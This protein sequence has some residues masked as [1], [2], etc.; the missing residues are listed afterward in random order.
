MKKVWFLFALVFLV[1]ATTGSGGALQNKPDWEDPSVIGINK[2]DPHASFVPYSDDRS[3]LEGKDP[4]Q[5]MSLN[6][7]WKFNYSKDPWHRPEGFYKPGFDA[8][9]WDTIPVPSNWEMLGYGT[10]IYTNYTYPFKKNAPKVTSRPRKSWTAYDARNPVGSYLKTFTVPDT[11]QGKEIYMVFHGVDSAFYLWINGEKVGYSQGSRLPAEFNVTDFLKPGGNRLAALV[12]RWCD[13]S[14]LEDQDFWRLSGIYRNVELVARPPLHVRDFYVRTDFDENYRDADF[15]LKIE[16]RNLENSGK[17]ASITAALFDDSGGKVFADL[18]K[19][20]TVDSKGR[21]TVT[22]TKHV[23]SPRKWSAEMPYLYQLL[24]TLKDNN[25]ETLESIPFRVGFRETEIKDSQILINGRPIYLKGA[26]RHEHD[27]DTG[28][29]VS[30]ESMI[31]DIKIMK[32]NNL[33]AVRTSHYPCTPEW[34]SLC[35]EYGLY[36]LDE[37]NIESHG[38]GVHMLQRTSMGPDYKEQHVDRIRRMVER[39]KNHPS[40]FA[41]SLGNEAGVGLNLSAERKWVNKHYPEFPVFYEQGFGVHSDALCPMYTPPDNLVRNW[42]LYGFGKPMFLVEYAHSMGN[43]VGDFKGYWEVMESHDF[44]QGGF[45]WDWVDQGLRK[46]T[47]DGEE[48]WAYGGDYGDEPNDGNFCLNGLVMPDRKPH[49]ALYEVKK[50]YQNIEV[51]PVD[52][53]AGRVIVRNKHFFRDLSFVKGRW[54]LAENGRNIKFGD[55]PELNIG[56]Q[57]EK[58]ITIDIEKPELEEGAEYHLLF[59]FHLME[60][61]QWADL[62][63]LMAWDQFKMPYDVPQA[64]DEEN[65]GLPAIEA[66]EADGKIVVKG[67]GLKI[68][69]GRKTGAL[70]SFNYKGRE[71]LAG[72]LLPNFWRAPTDNDRGNFMPVRQG[73]WK[74]AGKDRNVTDVKVEQASP[75]RVRVTVDSKLSAGASTFRTVYTLTGDGKIKVENDFRPS[76]GLPNLPRVGM[77][78]KVPGRYNTMQWFGRGPHES[79]SDRKWGAIVGVYEGK[80]KDLIHHYSY[81]QENGNRTDVRWVKFTDDD[82]VGLKACGMPLLNVSAWPYTQEALEEA[83]HTYELD[84][85]EDITVNLDHK[86]MGVGGDNSWGALPHSQFRLPAQPYSYTFTLA[87]TGT[88]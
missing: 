87:P 65:S 46:K 75:S 42:K 39:D 66:H 57:S 32:Q 58:E 31:E 61:T 22:F 16:L 79:Y 21:E 48:F 78:M 40:V 73:V 53:K 41:V 38:Y 63:H 60:K 70:E 25:G 4:T 84:Y 88:D 36:V 2:E 55:L 5:V 37:T 8:G 19:D 67:D 69:I 76:A 59:A 27:P 72:P 74:D 7:Q 11:W 83:T 81:P 64:G 1:G 56:P 80:V 6:G 29:Y 28:H 68:T 47:D 23:R 10:P 17:K 24:I 54:R 13:G 71:L 77:Q 35:D 34:Y 9:G 3:A 44:L 43:S 62:G 45:I 12:Y 15:N 86:Q 85:T 14:Y 82:G 51:E 33:N 20:V 26:N 30:R 49:P 52:L 18:T 50:F